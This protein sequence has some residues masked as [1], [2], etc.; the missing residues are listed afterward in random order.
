MKLSRQSTGL[1]N[2][3]FMQEAE[4]TYPRQ[5]RQLVAFAEKSRLLLH[6]LLWG[7]GHS[8]AAILIL[9][10]WLACGTRFS[11]YAVSNC[12]V[13]I[14][15]GALQRSGG[16]QGRK[17][18]PNATIIHIDMNPARSE[19]M[20]THTFCVRRCKEDLRSWWTWLMKRLPMVGINR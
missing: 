20:L 1:K 10:V 9:W 18:W 17:V 8:P 12:D 14:A 6:V 3:L 15:V 16:E 11:N 19:R 5:S 4:W 13:L 2:R 7:W